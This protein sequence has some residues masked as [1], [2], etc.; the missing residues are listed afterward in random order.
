[1]DDDDDEDSDVEQRAA[2]P[3]PPPPS[4]QA[5]PAG[6]PDFVYDTNLDQKARARLIE[7]EMNEQVRVRLVVLATGAC[8]LMTLL[9]RLRKIC[10]PEI[11]GHNC[12]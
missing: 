12:S 2:P 6:L 4:L 3:S 1:M 5:L 10:M 11:N 7:N 9:Y 8:F